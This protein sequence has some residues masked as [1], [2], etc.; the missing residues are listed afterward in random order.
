MSEH[1]VDIRR[2]LK[3]IA[4]ALDRAYP[5]TDTA[6]SDPEVE[7]TARRLSETPLSFSGI[8][9]PRR[10][11]NH[12]GDLRHPEVDRYPKPEGDHILHDDGHEGEEL[13]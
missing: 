12:Y 5:V 6:Y 9:E 4:D 3:R 2:Q 7:Q 13:E 10:R 11:T 8:H 1:E